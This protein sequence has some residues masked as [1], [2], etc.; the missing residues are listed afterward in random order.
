MEP[1]LPISCCEVSQVHTRTEIQ[2]QSEHLALGGQAS[3][4]LEDADEA[5]AA[6]RGDNGRQNYE[7][8]DDFEI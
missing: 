5:Q 1:R 4:A 6:V 2:S 7:Y 8:D 3:E